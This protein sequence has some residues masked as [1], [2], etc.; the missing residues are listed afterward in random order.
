MILFRPSK[1]S[2]FFEISIS[3]ISLLSEI[4]GLF[5]LENESLSL[6]FWRH[7][8]ILLIFLR[9]EF[10]A[11]FP[12]LSFSGFSLIVSLVEVEVVVVVAVSVAAVAAAT[13]AAAVVVVVSVAVVVVVMGIE[14]SW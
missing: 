8:N 2:L 3:E 7:W 11:S 1:I 14:L 10:L 4:L 5:K 6:E 9:I 12:S 13:V